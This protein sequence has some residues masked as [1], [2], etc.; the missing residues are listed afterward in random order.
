MENEIID[1]FY[2]ESKSQ[3][4]AYATFWRRVGASLLDGLILSPVNY[5]LIFLSMV[6]YKI[7]LLSILPPIISLFYKIYL[8]K[9]YGQ[10]LGKVI[11]GI[12]VTDDNFELMDYTQAI[13]RNYYHIIMLLFTVIKYVELFKM[14][15]FLQADTY[16]KM[17]QAQA[18]QA[19]TYVY[20]GYA[21]STL[22]LVD[23]V[24]MIKSNQNQTLHDRWAKT[25]VV[26]IV[27]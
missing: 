25:V 14:A 27:P 11:V 26:K 9:Q 20:L 18:A 16:M 10:T 17:I 3:S 4:V 13:K 15:S 12:K 8:E 2:E 6:Y 22:F 7:Y 24:L 23:C 5:G 1:E 21:F 19:S